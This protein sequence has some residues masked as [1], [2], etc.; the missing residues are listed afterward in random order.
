MIALYL[1]ACTIV[2]VAATVALPSGRD[3]DFARD[4]I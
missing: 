2:S 1:F 3:R 4:H